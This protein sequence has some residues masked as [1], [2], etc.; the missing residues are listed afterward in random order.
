[1]RP[2][3]PDDDRLLSTLPEGVAPDF[4]DRFYFNLHGSTPDPLIMIGAGVYPGTGVVDAYVLRVD[5]GVQRNLRLGDEP[6]DLATGALG[7]L[8][9]R[10]VEPLAE[11]ALA[12]GPNPLGVEFDVVWRA[13]TAAWRT[14]DI[15][16]DNGRGGQSRFGHFFQSG[17]YE[18]TLTLDGERRDVT[19]WLG[20]RDRSRGVRVVAGGQGLHLWV[21]AQFADRS[22]AFMLDED[23]SNQVIMCDGG[24]LWE[25]GETDPIVSVAH[26][27][28]FDD[29]LDFRRGELRIVTKSGEDFTLTADGTFGGGF[30][31][32]GGYGG[33]HGKR[34]GRNHVAYD[35]F[36]LDGS[37][38]P[39]NLDMPLTDR[40]AVFSLNGEQGAG[41]F[42]FAHS[43]SA[44]Y[45]YRP[46][47]DG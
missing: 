29:G 19:G 37:V 16:V 21:Q 10:I 28:Q 12:L 27:L 3:T 4:F 2:L 46:S 33:W 18:G 30:L 45:T 24:V 25:N 15:E 42:E 38:T 40:P 23:R 8:S 7:P 17:R 31:S 32:G 9:W 43:R 41:V 13:R 5:G 39:R 34:H 11:W 22:I 35:E 47:L 20:Q 44:R 1:M 14:E 26:R 6:G 36:P